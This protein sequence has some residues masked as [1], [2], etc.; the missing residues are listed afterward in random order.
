MIPDLGR[1]AGTVVAAYG[2]SLALL[3]GL[4]GL[5]VLRNVRVRRALARMER[6]TARPR[7][8]QA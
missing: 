5:S 4:V 3:A 2:I 1:Y 6:E 7:D 8:G